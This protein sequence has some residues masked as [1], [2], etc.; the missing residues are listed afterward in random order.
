[1]R[2]LFEHP[3][4]HVTVREAYGVNRPRPADRPWLGVCMVASIDGSTVIDSNSR[5]LS[6]KTDQEVLLTL[7]DLADVLLVGAA[8]VRIE[9]YGPPRKAGQRV[10]VVS[11]TGNVDVTSTLFTSGAGFL[12]IPE[13]APPTSVDAVRAG[14]GEVDF[15]GAL[16]Q[17][18]A[19]FVQAEGGAQLNGALSTAD[20]ID[21]IN[22]TISP[23]LAGG[24]GPR[25]TSGSVQMSRRMRLAHVL[26]DD[27]FL[28]TRYVRAR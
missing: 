13:D 20:V 23:Q 21:E 16:G 3:T 25:V 15:A 18:T 22:L 10:G 24:D 5:A 7:R 8:T 14:V 27:G 2:R 1:M 17:L 9:G 11:R 4:D 12:I 19:D 6:S 28:F 26:E